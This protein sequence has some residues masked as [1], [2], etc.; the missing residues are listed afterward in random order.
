MHIE[1]GLRELRVLKGFT[2][3][4]EET[5]LLPRDFCRLMTD[6]VDSSRSFW[7]HYS[8]MLQLGPLLLGFMVAIP[9][10][11]ILLAASYGFK[12]T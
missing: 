8:I 3:Q 6:L 12:K 1:L 11:F 7:R 2:L 10:P 4:H 9:L 5:F